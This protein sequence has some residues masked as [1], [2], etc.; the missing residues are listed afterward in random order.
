[1]HGGYKIKVP[2]I[3]RYEIS[4]NLTKEKI[5]KNYVEYYKGNQI[6]YLLK[7]SIILI[8]DGESN[9]LVMNEYVL[10]CIWEHSVVMHKYKFYVI[11]RNILK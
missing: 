1:M 9:I 6:F 10:N 3:I 11:N 2:Q 8:N 5:F 7:P 4:L